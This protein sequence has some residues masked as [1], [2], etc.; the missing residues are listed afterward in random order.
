MRINEMWIADK[1]MVAFVVDS[2]NIIKTLNVLWG[3]EVYAP[4]IH[5][6]GD[7]FDDE[8]RIFRHA[9]D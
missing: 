4:F 2:P 9:G 5:C 1:R 7:V 8:L 3:E 6:I